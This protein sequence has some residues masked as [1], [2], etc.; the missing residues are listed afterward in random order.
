MTGYAQSALLQREQQ[1][2]KVKGQPPHGLIRDLTEWTKSYS[3]L[4]VVE[5]GQ[6]GLAEA[7]LAEW[8]V[9]ET[10]T[11]ALFANSLKS[12]TLGA[13]WIPLNNRTLQWLLTAWA[14]AWRCEN[15]PLCHQREP[16]VCER[17][18]FVTFGCQMFNEQLNRE[19]LT[20]FW[21]DA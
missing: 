4:R 9:L 7:S 21:H 8:L 10:L 17:C 3:L 2:S 16:R 12:Y 18:L 14:S 15:D 20:E 1:P 13:L 6:I 5:E 11:F 19:F